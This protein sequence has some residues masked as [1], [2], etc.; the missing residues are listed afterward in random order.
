MC[1]FPANTSRSCLLW[2]KR[3]SI[4]EFPHEHRLSNEAESNIGAKE[5]SISPK[6]G[7]LAQGEEKKRPLICLSL[8][9][10][11]SNEGKLLT[12]CVTIERRTSIGNFIRVFSASSRSSSN[13]A[14][15]RTKRFADCSWTWC[16]WRRRRLRINRLEPFGWSVG[17]SS[18]WRDSCEGNELRMSRTSD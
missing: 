6:T 2:R 15:R 8:T 9:V 7:K 14:W 5:I 16:E 4:C 1:D 11:R 3:C 17:S 12:L 13:G 10:D 18:A